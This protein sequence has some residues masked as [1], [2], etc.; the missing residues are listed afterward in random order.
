MH[1]FLMGQATREIASSASSI[2]GPG[3]HDACIQVQPPAAGVAP[4]IP[5]TIR[6]RGR[7]E[8]GAGPVPGRQPTCLKIMRIKPITAAEILARHNPQSVAP[9]AR[10]V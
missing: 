3:S 2:R 1:S 10:G 4:L 8:A 9:N 5:R 7:A 6:H